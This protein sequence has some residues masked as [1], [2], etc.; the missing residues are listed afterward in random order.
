MMFSARELTNLKFVGGAVLLIIAAVLII[1]GF[2]VGHAL[3]SG[4]QQT[5]AAA[6]QSLW[7][8]VGVFFGVLILSYAFSYAMTHLA[9]TWRNDHALALLSPSSSLL[10]ATV[11][12]FGAFLGLWYAAFN[13]GVITDHSWTVAIILA[14]ITSP[15]AP[16]SWNPLAEATT[17]LKDALIK[18]VS[19]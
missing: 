13:L 19:K 14:A 1:I 2:F 12:A 8:I 18:K 10:R 15:F 17:D 9:K 4:L 3:A 6:E 16:L 7:E 11:L 5:V